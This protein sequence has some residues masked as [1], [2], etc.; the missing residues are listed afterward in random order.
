LESLRKEI[1]R[2]FDSFHPGT[3]DFPFGWRAF[4][5]EL[6]SADKRFA[7]APAADVSEKDNEYEITVE[8]AGM[9]VNDI[10]VKLS[11]D[12]LTIKGEKKEQKE[13][14]KKDYYL[15]ERCYGSFRR[16]FRLPAGVDSSK[17]EASFAKVVLTLKLPKRV[18]AQKSEKTIAIE[19]AS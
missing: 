18:E 11:D 10:E 5:L 16:T 6:P 9:D 15:C 14:R 17:I 19:T 3:R 7:I 12:V 2:L 1:D 13:E 8:L 4:E